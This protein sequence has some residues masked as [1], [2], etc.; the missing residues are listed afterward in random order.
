MRFLLAIL[1]SLS[2]VADADACL[3]CKRNTCRGNPCHYVKQV[4]APYVAPVVES[5]SVFVIQANY[6]SPLVGQGASAYSSNGGFQS[7]VYPLHDSR[8]AI[9]GAIE[10]V[11]AGQALVS[12]ALSETLQTNERL[13]QLYAPAVEVNERGIAG[14]R[15]L[16]AAG[17]NPAY[18]T[19]QQQS[20]VI[21]VGPNGVTSEKLTYEQALSITTRAG[22]AANTAI[23]EPPAVITAPTAA[24]PYPFTAKF[25]GKCHGLDNPSPS[26][27]FYIGLDS[28]VA[29]AM[30][31]KYR[32]MEKMVKSGAMP[33]GTSLT[34]DEKA[35][36][37]VE[38]NAMI[39]Q[40][41]SQSVS[42]K[43]Q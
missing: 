19:Q 16:N 1:V 39:E 29:A 26:K 3:L 27:G 9:S 18:N 10:V 13:S 28:N 14:E 7:Q 32:T 15:L 40:G 24:N 36:V 25:C 6:P 17:L 35:Q 30:D 22:V 37:L 34:A 31:D 5:P 2:F 20:F 33:Q 23:T 38:L 42:T 21:S 8:I 11:K 12:S 4:V 41:L 43:E